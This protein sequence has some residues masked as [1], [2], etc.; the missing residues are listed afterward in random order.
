MPFETSQTLLARL[1]KLCT[2]SYYSSFCDFGS[3]VSEDT[4]VDNPG[5]ASEKGLMAYL[6]MLTL[7]DEETN[8][9]AVDPSFTT[10]FDYLYP[11]AKNGVHDMILSL[12]KNGK[13]EFPT[14]LSQ[15]IVR[16]EIYDLKFFPISSST[17]HVNA[18]CLYSDIEDESGHVTRKIYYIC[19]GSYTMGDNGYYDADG[20]GQTDWGTWIDNAMLGIERDGSLE[21]G[22]SLAAFNA[23]M[24]ALHLRGEFDGVDDFEVIVSGHSKGGNIAKYITLFSNQV[25]LCISF[26]GVGFSDDF[27]RA[28]SLEIALNASKIVN[29]NPE[30]SYV[31]SLFNELEGSSNLYI[32][33]GLPDLDVG[34]IIELIGLEGDERDARMQQLIAYHVPTSMLN[35]N[36]MLNQTCQESTLSQF[37]HIVSK[38]AMDYIELNPFVDRNEVM[39]HVGVMLGT[40]FNDGAVPQQSLHP[41]SIEEDIVDWLIPDLY[42]NK[43]DLSSDDCKMLI[44]VIS[45]KLGTVALIGLVDYLI[46]KFSADDSGLDYNELNQLLSQQSHDLFISSTLASPPRDPL[47]IDL[48]GDNTINLTTVENGV[49]FDLDKNGFAEKTAWITGR[50]GFLVLD[51]NGNGI[52]DDG[53]ELFSDQVIMSTNERS[54]LGGFQALADLDFCEGSF[55]L[56]GRFVPHTYTQGAVLS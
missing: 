16:D 37:V 24:D 25:D 50:D 29:V 12:Y 28:H 22:E 18:A 52:I 3:S 31:G 55:A 48:G 36:Q 42:E 10:M 43:T 39:Y 32:N 8:N 30:V 13:L 56:A 38:Q 4:N 44:T 34:D 27:V 41:G 49:F 17:G 35:A 33:T 11:D 9:V 53:G 2:L 19:G 20:D 45:L 47:I 40:I 1:L 23:T 21:Q 46:S 7:E 14:G 26:D 6:S 15:F 51:R 54:V 5:N